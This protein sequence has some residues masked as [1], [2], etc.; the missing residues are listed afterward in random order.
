M[1]I[2]LD[3]QRRDDLLEVVKAG[4]TL[5][6]NGESFDFSPMDDGDTLPAIAIT[7]GW[8]SGDVDRVNGRLVIRMWLPNPWNYSPEQAFPEPLLN[9]PDGPVLLPRPRA[10]SEVEQAARDE[11]LSMIEAMKNAE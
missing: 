6:V 3:P 10:G 1:R 4:D 9:V 2:I 5:V 11:A 8:F 7:S